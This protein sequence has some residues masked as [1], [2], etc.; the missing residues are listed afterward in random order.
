LQDLER[1]QRALLGPN[2][3]G[4]SP[5]GECPENLRKG[6]EHFWSG[7]ERTDEDHN[8]HNDARRQAKRAS[9]DLEQHQPA[10]H[11]DRTLAAQPFRLVP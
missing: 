11:F 7:W 10:S 8:D 6:S 4:D 1:G 3:L 5:L 9:E 2:R